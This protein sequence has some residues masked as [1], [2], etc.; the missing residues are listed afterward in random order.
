M[1]SLVT[2]DWLLRNIQVSKT[3]PY[4]TEATSLLKHRIYLMSSVKFFFKIGLI[5][6]QMKEMLLVSLKSASR[7]CNSRYGHISLYTCVNI[8]HELDEIHGK[9]NN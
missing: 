2:F 3:E 7:R 1:V 9:Q 8:G 4:V 5:F 6:C